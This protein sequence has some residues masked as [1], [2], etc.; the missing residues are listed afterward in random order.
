[1]TP[2]PVVWSWPPFPGGTHLRETLAPAHRR[3]AKSGTLPETAM[4]AMRVVKSEARTSKA[5]TLL[6]HGSTGRY[7]VIDLLSRR[8]NRV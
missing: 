1:M 3:C 4:L 2:F 5:H 8:L 6:Y 7:I